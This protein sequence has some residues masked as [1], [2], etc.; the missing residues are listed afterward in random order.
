MK[1]ESEK[2]IN[3]NT[4]TLNQA[5][6]LGLILMKNIEKIKEL[7]TNGLDIN[8]IYQYLESA[9]DLGY[10]SN[11]VDAIQAGPEYLKAILMSEQEPD[12][13]YKYEINEKGA[14]VRII[15][16]EFRHLSYTSIE[17]DDNGNETLCATYKNLPIETLV[18]MAQ[19]ELAFEAKSLSYLS[20][21]QDIITTSYPN[22]T[23]PD[24]EEDFLN[25]NTLLNILKH[26]KGYYINRDNL[27]GSS[28]QLDKFL[29]N[30]STFQCNIS[31][32]TSK[33]LRAG[34]ES[35]PLKLFG[36]CKNSA[37]VLNI[38]TGNTA[39]SII[40]KLI[41]TELWSKIAIYVLPDLMGGI[42]DPF[43]AL[44]LLYSINIDE[45]IDS[46]GMLIIENMQAILDEFNTQENLSSLVSEDAQASV[47]LTGEIENIEI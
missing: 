25:I 44:S 38:E 28:G 24:K 41:P 12:I 10:H 14:K 11:L 9:N 19:E 43:I 27:Y 26:E 33:I 13:G 23:N 22:H 34:L 6:L 45:M 4:Q 37:P 32:E 3:S 20:E 1:R 35:N 42:T 39:D 2:V 16:E 15:K 5:P 36:I 21:I 46:D 17:I 18:S 47:D 8:Y 40:E 29:D 30:F 31:K 7:V